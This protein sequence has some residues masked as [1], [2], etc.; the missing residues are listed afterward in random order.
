VRSCARHSTPCAANCSINEYRLVDFD[1]KFPPMAGPIS[2]HCSGR[3]PSMVKVISRNDCV[4]AV[5]SH[6]AY[7]PFRLPEKGSL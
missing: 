7:R 3:K 1:V 6:H 4:T 2:K 5:S